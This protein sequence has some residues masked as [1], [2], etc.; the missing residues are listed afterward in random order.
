MAEEATTS[1]LDE[2][3]FER[4]LQI[5]EKER[6]H[7]VVTGW[8]K[9]FYRCFRFLVAVFATCLITLI[10]LGLIPPL[11][12]IYKL[13]EHY[14]SVTI[15]ISTGLIYIFFLCNLRII[16]HIFK[17]KRL[18]KRLG[19]APKL[20]QIFCQH[21]QLRAR[22]G[23]LF[24]FVSRL[25]NFSL[26]VIPAVVG[27]ILSCI[28]LFLLLTGNK[29]DRILW[30]IV[31]V[32]GLVL[33]AAFYIKRGKERLQ[34]FS[35]ISNLENS[36]REYKSKAQDAE[37]QGIEVSNK[38]LKQIAVI[39][40]SQIELDL[41]KATERYDKHAA[42]AYIVSRSPEASQAICDLDPKARVEVVEK[43]ETLSSEPHPSG[44]TRDP[45]GNRWRLKV[46]DTSLS[47][48]YTVDGEKRQIE[49]S[50]LASLT[51][52]PGPV[53]GGEDA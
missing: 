44:V 22:K 14:L 6:R 20:E 27:L 52:E 16:Y 11:S 36:L 34:F 9:F 2:R 33:P 47:L 29:E 4:T 53:P 1:Y 46:P 18:I 15:I 23:I 5:L 28:S 39:E 13:L 43:I 32:L 3:N 17:Y 38:E 10:I 37:T 24:S 51:A 19:L 48:I 50:G 30:V 40:R 41:A 35:E 25:H 26:S 8:Q 21:R 7:Y 42:S 49:I 31:F 12:D 45:D